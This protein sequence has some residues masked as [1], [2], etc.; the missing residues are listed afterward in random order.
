M[1]KQI[2]A[3]ICL[4]AG[5]VTNT[6]ATN[7]WTEKP[8]DFQY[9]MSIYV[10][11]SLANQDIYEIAAFCGEECR[12][13]GKLMTVGNGD[14]V[15]YMRIRS[16]KSSGE[17][18]TFRVYNSKIGKEVTAGESIT[19]E[20]QSVIGLPSEPFLLD[21]FQPGDVNGDRQITSQD[22]LLIL[23]AVAGTIALTE[24]QAMYGDVNGDGQITAQDASLILQY[25]AG[26]TSW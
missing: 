3:M 12:G 17:T 18:M 6:T 7:H 5:L 20:S 26:K 11:L 24:N 10:K 25:I 2:L 16:N 15:Y 4:L 23:Q 19:F 14:Q 21:V 9:D 13:V 8:Y 1:R 22:A